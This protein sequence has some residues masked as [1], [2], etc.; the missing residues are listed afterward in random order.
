MP[1]L[2]G[3]DRSTVKNTKPYDGRPDMHTEL[4]AG[5]DKTFESGYTKTKSWGMASTAGI[6]LQPLG[7]ELSGNAT[8]K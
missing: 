4:N 2:K 7:L 5:A 8:T 6:L 1:N 3:T